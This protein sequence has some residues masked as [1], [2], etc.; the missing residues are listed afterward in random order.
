MLFPRRQKATGGRGFPFF[1]PHP[2]ERRLIGLSN[3]R[4]FPKTLYQ[5]LSLRCLR[6]FSIF[7]KV[8]FCAG[9]ALLQPKA[10]CRPSPPARPLPPGPGEGA[11]PQGRWGG[12]GAW[13]SPVQGEVRMV[14]KLPTATK[15]PLP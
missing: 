4:V 14:P 11:P 7:A 13:G 12:V 5:G 10:A 2:S 8:R 9:V 6:G 15:V 3:A 1:L